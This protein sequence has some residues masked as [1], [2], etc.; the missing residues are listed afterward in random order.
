MTNNKK[1][2]NTIVEG[3]HSIYNKIMNSGLNK[4]VDFSE[5]IEYSMNE[6]ARLC[7]ESIDD[8]P[9]ICEIGIVECAVYKV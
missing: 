2:N 4:A 7:I 5:L 8:V 1:L 3:M 9:E 6:T